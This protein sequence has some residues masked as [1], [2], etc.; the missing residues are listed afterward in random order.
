MGACVRRPESTVGSGGRLDMGV[1]RA[2]GVTCHALSA[3]SPESLG[4]VWPGA[5]HIGDNEV[6]HG[7]NDH[8]VFDVLL[9]GV[10]DSR[11]PFA[12]RPS[13][14]HRGV[15]DASATAHNGVCAVEYGA[16]KMPNGIPLNR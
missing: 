14:L 10:G 15:M 11:H 5:G 12:P 9:G 8:Y 16:L 7:S 13:Y 2:G 1:W 4:L 3:A 6:Q